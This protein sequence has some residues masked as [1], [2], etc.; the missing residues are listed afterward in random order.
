MRIL[1]ISLII[2]FAA[3]SM[4]DMTKGDWGSGGGNAIVC[5]KQG[6]LATGETEIDI[7]EEVKRNKNIIPDQF[8]KYIESIEM[9]DLYEA[10][11]RRGIG[12]K[13][14]E[15]IEIRENEKIYDYIDRVANRFGR[16]NHSV[17]A[18]VEEGKSLIPDSRLVFNDFPVNYQNDLGA[19]TLPGSNCV[20]STIAA[21]VNYNNF[22]E[23]HIDTRL[24]E[25]PKHSKQSQATLVLHELIYASTRRHF[26]HKDSGATRNI[27]RMLISY[28][29]SLTE[30][31]VA[32]SLYAL[33]LF[34][35]EI[36]SDIVN[37]FKLSNTMEIV[38][39][40]LNFFIESL[41]N[42]SLSTSEKLDLGKLK[43]FIVDTAISDEIA[44]SL[45]EIKHFSGLSS[46]VT[47]GFLSGK[48]KEIWLKFKMKLSHIVHNVK[49]RINRFQTDLNDSIEIE[50]ESTNT[51]SEDKENIKIH[52]DI[53]LKYNGFD[54]S[55]NSVGAHIIDN[56]LNINKFTFK[57]NL[58]EH[59]L[60]VKSCENN[61]CFNNIL[62]NNIIPKE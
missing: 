15:I 29:E 24:F 50:F 44:Y 10:K 6:V 59:L 48:N 12:S 9:Y 14:A 46:I 37:E 62:L 61:V 11:K 31:S 23:A 51:T 47:R 18:I 5:F 16:T 28:H 43:K 13:P 57:K 27:V 26:N 35:A 53:Y 30:K 52:L 22:F 39:T 56:A 4:L 42:E 7:V 58:F 19:V 45:D 36:E 32:Q 41:K 2:S 49:K 20:I 1:L 8:L 25:H 54:L 34:G 40:Y 3:F 55:S 21:Q 33:K 17:K 38:S 60:Y